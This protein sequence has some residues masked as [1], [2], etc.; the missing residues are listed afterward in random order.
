MTSEDIRKHLRQH[1]VYGQL[2]FPIACKQTAF[3][4]ETFVNIFTFTRHLST[5]HDLNLRPPSP[6]ATV[7]PNNPQERDA[8]SAS[9]GSSQEM[10]E[11][12]DMDV[13]LVG[14][15]EELTNEDFSQDLNTFKQ[16]YEKDI[17]EKVMA[18]RAMSNV[19]LSLSIE[20]AQNF[21]SLTVK[22][23]NF[24]KQ[25]FTSGIVASE[26]LQNLSEIS[27]VFS[28]FTSEHKMRKKYEKHPKFIATDSVPIG[29]DGDCYQYV[30]IPR[31]LK[32]VTLS[33]AYCELLLETYSSPDIG[34]YSSYQDGT[35]FKQQKLVSGDK[36][37]VLNIQLYADGLGLTNPIGSAA[38][39]HNSTMIYFSV[40]NIGPSRN[41]SIEH[42]HLV[43]A[44]NTKNIKAEGGLS[45]V[46]RMIY[47]DLKQ[48]ET[49]GFEVDILG[50][51]KYKVYAILSQLTADNLALNHM[52]GLLES[53]SHDF[54]CALCYATKAQ[55]QTCFKESMF[56]LRDPDQYQED[57][58]QLHQSPHLP[59]VRGVKQPC[60]LD[61]LEH[62][63]VMDNWV[64]DVMHTVRT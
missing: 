39:I 47:D 16:D 8:P 29:Y 48:L 30:S 11:V 33:Q 7:N 58:R 46:Q 1:H 9:N 50:R 53:F 34:T 2:T 5:T 21:K 62:W 23:L 52:L 51:G 10:S 37:I 20:F 12:Q 41:A 43:A 3:C 26:F 59:H 54:C 15:L 35:R 28:S 57:L 31:T 42:L 55:M 6:V 27:S 45:T 32:S 36:T 19:P 44:V 17:F 14:D 18:I 38:T 61:N 22:L 64:N 40:L 60:L 63:K 25:M 13:D 4:G 56:V 49:V 24:I